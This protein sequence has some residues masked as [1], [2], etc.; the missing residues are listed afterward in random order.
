MLIFFAITFILFPMWEKR[1][2]RLRFWCWCWT[3][4][5]TSCS[6]NLDNFQNVIVKCVTTARTFVAMLFAL[7]LDSHDLKHL[8]WE[9]S[10]ENVFV[11]YPLNIR[12]YL[13]HF[14]YDDAPL[15]FHVFLVVRFIKVSLRFPQINDHLWW[16]SIRCTDLGAFPW[17]LFRLGSLI[18]GLKTKR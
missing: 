16:V 18:W 1:T 11:I 3:A 15:L 5:I 6:I 2:I 8:I 17:L 7:R 4:R 12:D 10:R 13:W 14:A 9:K